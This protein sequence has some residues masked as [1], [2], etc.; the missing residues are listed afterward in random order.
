MRDVW[1]RHRVHGLARSIV[2]ADNLLAQA[3]ALLTCPTMLILGEDDK[4]IPPTFSS[5]LATLCPHESE[6]HSF[7]GCGHAFAHRYFGTLHSVQRTAGPIYAV[8]RLAEYLL[9]E[10][11]QTDR[12]TDVP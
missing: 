7:P 12:Q 11:R 8:T 5:S 1:A 4:M 3:L 6:G 2:L 9:G 10:H